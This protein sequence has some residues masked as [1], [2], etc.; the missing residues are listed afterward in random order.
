MTSNEIRAAMHRAN[1][2]GP[3]YGSD[4]HTLAACVEEL[5]EQLK[6][7]HQALK[8]MTTVDSQTKEVRGAPNVLTTHELL[9]MYE[10]DCRY[11]AALEGDSDADQ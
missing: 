9:R 4:A 1:N 7:A 8:Q 11:R 2:D 3:I 5:Y 10:T 6:I